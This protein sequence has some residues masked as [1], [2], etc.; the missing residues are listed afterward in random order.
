MDIIFPCKSS[1]II[2]FKVCL[3][4]DTESAVYFIISSIPSAIE[5]NMFT[6]CGSN[7]EMRNCLFNLMDNFHTMSCFVTSEKV[8]VK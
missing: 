1:Q 7:F 4:E 2:F 8:N 3:A 6:T 5:Y